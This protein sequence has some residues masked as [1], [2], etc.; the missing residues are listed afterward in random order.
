M[1]SIY[2]LYRT[3]V[4]THFIVQM[5]SAMKNPWAIGGNLTS[6]SSGRYSAHQSEHHCSIDM[7]DSDGNGN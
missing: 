6:K 3:S 4:P 2:V 1:G 7:F 5:S